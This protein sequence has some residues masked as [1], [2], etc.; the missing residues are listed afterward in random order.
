[1]PTTPTIIPTPPPAPISSPEP[2]RS[3]AD[4]EKRVTMSNKLL[5]TLN[6][7]RISAASLTTELQKMYNAAESAANEERAFAASGNRLESQTKIRLPRTILTRLESARDSLQSATEACAKQR[8][9]LEALVS[10]LSSA[11]RQHTLTR[12]RGD[13]AKMN[14]SM[15]TFCKLAND[16]YG[17]I[18]E[19]QCGML[20]VW[21]DLFGDGTDNIIT[22][23]RDLYRLG[24]QLNF[25][26]NS[27]GWG[28][29]K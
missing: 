11:R 19:N 21:S 29:G 18:E 16:V 28:G 2:P 9:T 26:A 8:T 24:A 13:V 22:R 15:A 3:L 7:T 23:K 20:I 10:E 17:T 6:S 12:I 4:L 1:M 27:E 5:D 25:A 14:A